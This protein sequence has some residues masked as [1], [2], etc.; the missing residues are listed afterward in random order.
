MSN[1]DIGGLIAGPASASAAPRFA[2]WAK[3][4]DFRNAGV[5]IRAAIVMRAAAQRGVAIDWFKEEDVQRYRCV[6]VS[7][8]HDDETLLRLQRFKQDGGRFVLD[9]CDNH[10]IPASQKPKHLHRCENVRAL[11]AMANAIV[12]SSDTL[13]Q[14]VRRECPTADRIVVIGDPPDDLSIIKTPLWHRYVSNWQL[15]RECARLN[16]VAPAG[17]ARLIWFGASGGHRKLSGLI[18]LA[19]IAPMISQLAQTHPLHLTVVTDNLKLHKEWI[20]PTLPSSRYIAW[21]PRTFDSL[22]RQQHIVLIPAQ[23]NE[24]TACKTDNRVVT[25]LRAGLAVVADTVPSYAPYD[26][27]IMLGNM[28]EGLRQYLTNPARRAADASRGQAMVISAD[29]T[30]RVLSQWL[31]LLNCA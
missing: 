8:R 16:S 25:A 26:G 17:V 1:R 11:A 18:D 6:V 19:R 30:E 13:A 3:T 24:Y 12:T 14:I 5:R 15:S 10:F 27:T 23:S 21:N 7:G 2:W 20:A 4:M 29:S 28:E 31:D 9:L 22:L